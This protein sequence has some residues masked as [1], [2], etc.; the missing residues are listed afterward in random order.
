M[1][2]LRRGPRGDDFCCRRCDRSGITDPYERT[3]AHRLREERFDERVRSVVRAIAVGLAVVVG[4][5][6]GAVSLVAYFAH[7]GSP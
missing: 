7:W 6:G 3:A 5:L 1:I 4:A 2:A